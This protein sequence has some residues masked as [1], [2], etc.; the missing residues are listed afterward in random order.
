MDFERGEREKKEGG[1]PRLGR[2]EAGEMI[3]EREGE[4]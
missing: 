4:G 3:E 1:S 2:V